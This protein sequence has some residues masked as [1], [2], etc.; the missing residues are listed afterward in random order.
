M[1]PDR[2]A[3]ATPP[4]TIRLERTRGALRAM[5]LNDM[6]PGVAV[7]LGGLSLLS[8]EGQ[9]VFAITSL[10]AGAALCAAGVRE[11]R[12]SEESTS[13]FGWVDVC[14]GVVALLTALATYRPHK[15]FQPATLGIV[16][17]VL[18]LVRGLFPQ[19]F[20]R[21]RSLRLGE[22][23]FS[24]RISP[25]RSCRRTWPELE[26]IETMP[27]ALT[28][29]HRDGRVRTVSLRSV[30]NAEQ[31]IDALLRFARAHGVAVPERA[32]GPTA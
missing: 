23:G 20:P 22:G 5:L 31:V 28:L 1:H 18:L 32:D 9:R 25:L 15:T 14:G 4:E 27:R 24:L 2:E 17:A 8:L 12:S 13:R 10:F 3:P 7:L 6:L 19:L 26:R 21:L 29:H 30:A 11:W 16:V